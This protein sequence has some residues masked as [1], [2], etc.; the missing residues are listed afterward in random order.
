MQSIEKLSQIKIL[1]GTDSIKTGQAKKSKNSQSLD[2]KSELS[3]EIK[4]GSVEPL[5]FSK[6]AM[7]RISSRGISL[8]ESEIS[9][10]SAALSKADDKGIRDSLVMLNDTAFIVSVR[11]KTVITAI[12]KENFKQKV[13]TNIDGVVI[14]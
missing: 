10:L 5:K 9:S 7:D 14:L 8:T 2:F 11:N 12:D 13:I 6:H 1:N 4:A 3:S